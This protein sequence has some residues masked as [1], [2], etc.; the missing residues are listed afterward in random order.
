MTYFEGPE[1]VE[2]PKRIGV[3]RFRADLVVINILDMCTQIICWCFIVVKGNELVCFHAR[4]GGVT[5]GNLDEN[6]VYCGGSW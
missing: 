1:N 3:L 5:G 2:F 6:K 4:M